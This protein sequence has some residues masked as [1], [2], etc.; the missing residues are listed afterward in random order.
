[1]NKVRN[2][3][4]GVGLAGVTALGVSAELFNN[5]GATR[6][7]SENSEALTVKDKCLELGALATSQG[8]ASISVVLQDPNTHQF[9]ACWYSSH[10]REIVRDHSSPTGYVVEQKPTVAK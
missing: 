6:R 8:E 9:V 2:A 10:R 5:G 7:L 3:A 4:L 1:M